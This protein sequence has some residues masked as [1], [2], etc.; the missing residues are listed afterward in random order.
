MV[1]AAVHCMTP[2]D[3]PVTFDNAKSRMR[4]VHLGEEGSDSAC[5]SRV[6]SSIVCDSIA[7]T[8]DFIKSPTSFKELGA[9]SMTSAFPMR[10][11]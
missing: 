2:A 11:L 3:S 1:M 6:L 5:S 10:W 9:I 4:I 8:K 7:G